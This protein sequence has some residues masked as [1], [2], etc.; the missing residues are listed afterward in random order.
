M[1]SDEFEKFGDNHF[2]RGQTKTKMFI[3]KIIHFIK[4]IQ[5]IHS[6]QL[7]IFLK[8]QNIYSKQISIF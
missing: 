1:I 6:K 7:L 5:N 8:I 3:Q 4:K 2:R